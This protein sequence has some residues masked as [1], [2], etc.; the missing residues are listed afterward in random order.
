MNKRKWCVKFC[1]VIVLFALTG[2]VAF[3]QSA[4]FFTSVFESESITWE[5]A[6]F[7]AMVGT[8]RL[9]D[10]VSPSQAW[11]ALSKTQW[12]TNIPERTSAITVA[13]YSYLLAK[14]F[15]VRGGLFYSLFGGERYAYREMVFKKVV[16][17]SFD[18]SS[19]ITGNDA[20]KV[21]EK[22]M[23]F[24]PLKDVDAQMEAGK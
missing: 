23:A 1:M 16:P 10:N 5:Q 19:V 14:A 4:A 11:E 9:A 8:D 17:G 15:D 13:Q 12:Y 22:A 2:T 21:L 24:F 3:A 7:L 6:S 18:P 20:M